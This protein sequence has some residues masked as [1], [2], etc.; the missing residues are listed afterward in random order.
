MHTRP[1]LEE[2]VAEQRKRS[3]LKLPDPPEPGSGFDLN[4]VMKS[5]Y[6]FS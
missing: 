3:G 1:L 5:R 6:F 4:N 2:F